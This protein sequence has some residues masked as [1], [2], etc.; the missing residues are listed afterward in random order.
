MS[1]PYFRNLSEKADAAGRGPAASLLLPP[2]VDERS[3][4]W[5]SRLPVGLLI[6]GE[7]GLV[8]VHIDLHVLLLRDPR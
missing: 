5:G 8:L 4:L 3:D 7:L 2:W 6:G 1:T